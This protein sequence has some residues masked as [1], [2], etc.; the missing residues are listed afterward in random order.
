MEAGAS[1]V[2][3]IP[4]SSLV[5]IPDRAIRHRHIPAAAAPTAQP[6]Y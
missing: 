5:H 3:Q 6:P 2:L 4:V 1:E